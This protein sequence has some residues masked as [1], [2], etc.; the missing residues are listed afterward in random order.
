MRRATVILAIAMVAGCSSPTPFTV[1]WEYADDEPEF[2][3]LERCFSDELAVAKST[4]VAEISGVVSRR[5]AEAMRRLL[6]TIEAG[7]TPTEREYRRAG[8]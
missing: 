1:A 4:G 8:C 2:A 3:L 6:Q 5:R 7:N